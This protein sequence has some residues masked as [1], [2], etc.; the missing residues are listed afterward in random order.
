GYQE[1]QG[2]SMATPVVAGVAALILA[3]NPGISLDELRARLLNSV[4]PL[5]SLKGK[6]ATGGRVNAAKALGSQ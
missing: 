4:D 5:P 1:K 6:V 3:A 2:T